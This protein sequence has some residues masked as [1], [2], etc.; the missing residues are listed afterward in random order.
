MLV[1]CDPVKMPAV[2]GTSATSPSGGNILSIILDRGAPRYVPDQNSW[3]WRFSGKSSGAN[4]TER[5]ALESVFSRIT[6]VPSLG[7]GTFIAIAVVV[8]VLALLVGPVDAIVLA[9]RDFASTH[10]RRRCCGSR[11]RPPRAWRLR[12]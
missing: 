11:L 6:R 1:S 12:C 4:E 2:V 9:G 10:G 8:L 3:A 5:A 7:H